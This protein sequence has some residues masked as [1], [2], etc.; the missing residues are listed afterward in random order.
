M[1]SWA[2]RYSG[3]PSA[4]TSK[5]LLSGRSCR[6]RS[7]SRIITLV[8]TLAPASLHTRAAADSGA[9]PRPSTPTCAQAARGWPRE[10]SGRPH[11]QL[12]EEGPSSASHSLSDTR[13][14]NHNTILKFGQ[15][16]LATW[17]TRPRCPEQ[18]CP[19]PQSGQWISLP[20]STTVRDLRRVQPSGYCTRPPI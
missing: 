9:Y 3:K 14:L 11:R 20:N 10:S 5:R 6:K 4:T 12:R 8:D 2:P 7:M 17:P 1:A 19:P 13:P 16:G 15:L 18:P